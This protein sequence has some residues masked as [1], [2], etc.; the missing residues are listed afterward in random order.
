MARDADEFI[1][2]FH[3]M[4]PKKKPPPPEPPKKP[5]RKRKKLK[6]KIK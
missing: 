6:R 3:A 5:A 2:S 1:A 4:S